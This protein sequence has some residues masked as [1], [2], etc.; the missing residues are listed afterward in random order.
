MTVFD[1]HLWLPIA[2]P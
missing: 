1:Y 2:V